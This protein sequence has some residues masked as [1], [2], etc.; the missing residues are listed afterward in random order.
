MC[1]ISAASVGYDWSK[2]IQH[3]SLLCTSCCADCS[4]RALGE[5]FVARGTGTMVCFDVPSTKLMNNQKRRRK[6]RTRWSIVRVS[7]DGSAGEWNVCVNG[8][9][10]YSCKAGC[11]NLS[12]SWFSASTMS[13]ISS[14]SAVP[15]LWASTSA[16][17]TPARPQHP[18]T[19]RHGS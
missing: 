18:H 19:S 10:K 7:Q 15:S 5:C 6:I 11:C 8:S 12:S 1:T 17:S 9:E 4:G 13:S 14:S 2:N 16:A 3:R